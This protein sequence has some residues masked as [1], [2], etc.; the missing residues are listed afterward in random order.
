MQTVVNKLLTNYTQ[1]GDGSHSILFLHGWADNSLTFSQLAKEVVAKNQ[2]Y[3]AILLDL[4]GF[5]GTQAPATAWDLPDYAE[6]VAQF[7]VKVKLK[8]V[9]IVG[10]SNGGAI[11]I[12][13]IANGVLETDKLILIASAGIRN[14]SLKKHALRALAKPAKLA[15]RAA[16]KTTQ[17]RIKQKLYNAIGSD[18]L[19]AEHMQ[20]TFKNIVAYDV[21]LEAAKITVSACLIYGESDTATPPAYGRL[22]AANMPKATLEVIPLSGHFVHHEQVYKVARIC[23]DFIGNVKK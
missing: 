23:N 7:L 16:P 5:G 10:H 1:V 8:P 9:I 3:A 14:T 22:L 12:N 2:N 13:G 11:A 15:L 6:F 21:R 4:P 17:K 20:D 18:Y 19:I